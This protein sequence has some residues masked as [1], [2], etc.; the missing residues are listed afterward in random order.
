MRCVAEFYLNDMEWIRRKIDYLLDH[1]EC[2]QEDNLL[3]ILLSSKIRNVLH[4][5]KAYYVII[6]FVCFD[7][8]NFVK[9]I[10]GFSI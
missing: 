5:N 3:M 8:N 2:Q 1:H 4:L 9:E 10:L 7:I 6:T